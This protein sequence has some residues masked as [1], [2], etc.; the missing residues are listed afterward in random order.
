MPDSERTF[1]LLETRE[2]EMFIPVK[3]EIDLGDR[4][5]LSKLSSTGAES[6]DAQRHWT[7]GGW[8]PKQVKQNNESGKKRA[9]VLREPKVRNPNYSMFAKATILTIHFD[10]TL[11]A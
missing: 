8:Q 10:Q 9:C 7:Y 5:L 3:K 11:G 2:I 1:E 6:A 4:F